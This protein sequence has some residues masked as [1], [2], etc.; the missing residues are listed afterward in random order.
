MDLTSGQ[1]ISAEI[2]IV[3]VTVDGKTVYLPQHIDHPNSLQEVTIDGDTSFRF[4]IPHDLCTIY[5]E[6]STWGKFAHISTVLGILLG[7][8]GFWMAFKGGT[9][10][11][12]D[13]DFEEDEEWDEEDVLDELEDI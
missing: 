2:T 12:D 7:G 6:D 1:A 5:G 10:D 11:E 3:N 9:S 13:E 8:I 4:A